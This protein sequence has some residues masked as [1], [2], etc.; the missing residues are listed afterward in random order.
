[1]APLSLTL[2][3]GFRARLD[4]DQPLVIPI[5]KAQALLSYL[6]LP[7]GQAHSR[8]KLAALLWGDMRDAQAR[9]GLRQALFAL[10]KAFGASSPLR[11][12]GETVGLDPAYVVGDVAALEQRG[13]DGRRAGLWDVA[14]V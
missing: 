1:M 5:R 14:R 10:R 7:L 3:G 8:E 6:A 4:G 12:V 2:L 11:M 9:A 13:G